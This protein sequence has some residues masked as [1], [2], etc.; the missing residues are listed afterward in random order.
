MEQM[1]ERRARFP[2]QK[3]SGDEFKGASASL[4]FKLH[5]RSI[6]EVRE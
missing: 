3:Q 6:F 4:F 1:I 5:G 2:A